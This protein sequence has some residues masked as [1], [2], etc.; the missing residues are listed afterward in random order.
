[1]KGKAI[2]LCV[3]LLLTLLS[4]QTAKADVT[5][6]KVSPYDQTHDGKGYFSQ[7]DL[8][9]TSVQI[10][11]NDP[12]QINF[13]LWFKD[14]PRVNMFN[15]GLGS[16]AYVGIDYN[17]DGYDEIWLSV[18][19]QTLRGDLIP[20]KSKA[21]SLRDS[22]FLDCETNIFTNINAGQ[23][24]VGFSVSRSC[25]G[26]PNIFKIYG[27]AQYDSKNSESYY[28]L[29]P[30]PA[31][32]VNLASHN[33]GVGVNGKNKGNSFNLPET[34]ANAST[35]VSN[36]S[37]PPKDLTKLSEDLLP[38]VVTVECAL[39]NGEIGVGT[40]WS[41]DAKLSTD[42]LAAGY[43]TIVITNYH[44]IEDCLKDKVITLLLS[45]GS[46]VSGT[47]VSWHEEFDVAGIATTVSIPALQWIGS[48]PKQGWWVGVL[49]SPLAVSNI[50]TTGIISSVDN[51]SKVFTITAPINPGNSGGPVFDS[52]GR[53]LGLATSANLLDS[54]ELAQTFNNAHGVPLLCSF[55]IK[56]TTEKDPWNAVSKYKSNEAKEEVS[57]GSENKN[58]VVDEFNK[59]ITDKIS[60]LDINRCLSYNGELKLAIFNANNASIEFPAYAQS[61]RNLVKV[62]P[63]AMDCATLKPN[64]FDAELKAN[65][66]LLAAFQSAL[67]GAIS[68]AKVK[69]DKTIICVKG[70]VIKK[71]T[72][73]NPKCPKG[74]NKK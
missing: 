58:P 52:T 47:I 27:K 2:V 7:Y 26:L 33:A 49:G 24:W 65:Q 22:K 14:V 57:K 19:L 70:K 68:R 15:D 45:N 31:M 74:Y 21:Y 35:Y 62:S 10:F 37:T 50:L 38:S 43:K 25:L 72:G 5:F 18:L 46:R 3:A 66:A 20:V 59:E 41:A 32:Q 11:D 29:A 39:R 44:V 60:D 28:D 12:D 63:T 4:A 71:V 61:F 53:V 36:F 69:K 13:Y 30:Y 42:L 16:Y 1:M 64:T 40:G 54:G 34:I 6:N 67:S 56:C 55:V 9:Y 23:K 73:L 51:K 8:E 48:T 17:S